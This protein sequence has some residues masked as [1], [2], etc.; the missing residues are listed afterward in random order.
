[1]PAKGCSGVKEEGTVQVPN[2][3][4]YMFV[5]HLKY[6]YVDIDAYVRTGRSQ[7]DSIEPSEGTCWCKPWSKP[8][9]TITGA[10]PPKGK[11]QATSEGREGK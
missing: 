11:G 8:H 4:L 6:A 3:C 2:V 7:P 10:T 5:T 1:M 9:C